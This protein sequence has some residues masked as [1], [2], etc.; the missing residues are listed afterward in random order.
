MPAIIQP[1]TV[2]SV[3]LTTRGKVV[4]QKPTPTAEHRNTARGFLDFLRIAL[5][6]TPV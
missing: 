5:S 4:R 1:K 6:A 2:K 3:P